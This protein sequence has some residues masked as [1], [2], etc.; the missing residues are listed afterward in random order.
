M[1]IVHL[2][3]EWETIR[4]RLQQGFLSTATVKIAKLKIKSQTFAETFG[5]WSNNG[6]ITIDGFFELGF[7]ASAATNTTPPFINMVNQKLILQP[8]FSLWLHQ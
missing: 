7:P 2:R 8:V 5:V 3:Q 1:K 4:R 6:K